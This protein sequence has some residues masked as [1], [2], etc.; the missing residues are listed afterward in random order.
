MNTSYP[1]GWV[2]AVA[3]T[4]LGVASTAAAQNIYKCPFGKGVE[5]TDR[6][7]P[8]HT[9]KLIHQA[10]DTEIIDQY[11]DLGRID[12]AE[13][14]AASRNLMGLYHS[15]LAV[16]QRRQQVR[17]QRQL[18][19]AKAEQAQSV[20][21][22]RDAKQQAL[23]DQQARQARLLAEN[24]VL[25]EQNAHYRDALNRPGYNYVPNYWGAG[26]QRRG[27]RDGDGRHHHDRDDHHVKPIDK[28][29]FHPCQ[30]LAGG[31]VKC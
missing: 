20:Q 25:R 4:L 23:A 8:G 30:Q 1:S 31:R 11:L 21:A 19:D 3:I 26:R 29:V 28:P 17:Q 6:P 22:V 2:V 9:G 10:D 14:Y 18:A 24:D 13:R 27:E 15:R 16:Y 12:A 5:Y 7:C